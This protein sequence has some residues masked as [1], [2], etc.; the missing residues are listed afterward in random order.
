VDSD[1]PPGWVCNQTG[2]GYCYEPIFKES[3]FQT[4]PK[5]DSK[6]DHESKPTLDGED[7]CSDCSEGKDSS[8]GG[9]DGPGWDVLA[10]GS[11]GRDCKQLE[12]DKDEAMKANDEAWRKVKQCID[13]GLGCS[14][15]E[16]DDLHKEWQ[17][18]SKKEHAAV[19]AHQ[20]CIK[21]KTYS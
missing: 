17:E 12:V 1:C 2:G 14:E 21:P 13:K 18:A 11:S 5:D 19:Q 8:L 10:D 15:K 9:N 16:L 6:L 3:A 20:E 4:V 7:D